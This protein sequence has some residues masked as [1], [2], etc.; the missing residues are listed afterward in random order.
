MNKTVRSFLLG[1]T[2]LTMFIVL[3]G[4]I[5]YNVY[6]ARYFKAFPL[7]PLFFYAFGT[8]SILVFD[9][10]RRRLPNQIFNLYMGMKVVKMLL[11]IAILAVYVTL[12]GRQKVAFSLTFAA[13][14]VCHMVYETMFFFAFEMGKK[15]K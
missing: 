15:K 3:C 8:A 7:I 4:L 10:L 5:L 9:I 1:Q 12:V 14:Y 6:P 13:V 2:V 11:S